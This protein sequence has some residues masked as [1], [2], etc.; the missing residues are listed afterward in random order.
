IAALLHDTV[1]D[2]DMTLEEIG[3]QFGPD[4]QRLV[5]GLSKIAKIEQIGLEREVNSIRKMFIAMSEDIRVILVKLADRLHNI[6]TIDNMP[7]EKQKRIANET[8]NIFAPIADR[9]GIFKIKVEL[10]DIC[11]RILHPLEYRD[12]EKKLNNYHKKQD[13]ILE[14]CSYQLRQKLQENQVPI[15][16]ISYRT[17][18]KYS[19]FRKM[20]KRQEFN[21]EEIYDVFAL[22]IITDNINN[23]YLA[24]GLI[25]K[26]WTP[27]PNRIKD[28]FAVPKHNGYESLHTTIMGLNP[29]YPVEIQI[30]TPE[31]HEAAE[32]GVAA[33]WAYKENPK[34]KNSAWVQ[35]LMLLSK[36]I[37]ESNNNFL[38]NI[39]KDPLRE[40][41][42][43]LTPKGDVKDLPLGAT[44]IDFA[45][46]VHSEVGNHLISAKV[47]NKAVSLDHS[48]Q[49]G[50]I[51]EVRTDK[52][53]HPN[54]AWINV[55]KSN[56][57]R[58]AIRS[59]L[60]T[61]SHEDLL[62]LG[63][64]EINKFLQKLG[65][66]LLDANYSIL[67]NYAK[68]ELELKDRE[69]LLVKIGEGQEKASDVVKNIFYQ[70][71]PSQK[72]IAIIQA[73]PQTNEELAK[74]ILI[75]NEKNMNVRISSCCKPQF[76]EK[77]T[78]FVTRGG[79]V[80][81]HRLN[82]S[83]VTKATEDRFVECRWEGDPVPFEVGFE[84][85]IDNQPGIGLQI[86]EIFAKYKV[87]VTQIN[88]RTNKARN[89]SYM[90]TVCEVEDLDQI[91]W[92][93]DEINKIHSIQKMDYQIKN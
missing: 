60:R 50:D 84:F 85:V 28:Y 32:K 35:S 72:G 64:E 80:S 79:Y 76:K 74:K 24:L 47:N 83:F 19:I 89:L 44:P 27:L 67:K 3:R 43:V 14:R 12:I 90:T 9:L 59:Y 41:V 16:D 18:D 56:Q 68:P 29:H 38:E 7:P 48:L 92:L 39:K 69:N 15:M 46:S 22:R 70:K 93:A 66:P 30:R 10:E 54:P 34:A 6:R 49:N 5:D 45:Y 36:D 63:R 62:R 52:N 73:P 13:H 55:V 17:K 31:A 51:V 88:L 87:N 8:L 53:R 91:T 26:F 25:H 61:Q 33:H 75:M 20:Q 2:T 11:F 4:V 58:S 23:C 57:A 81:I 37:E 42:Y 77:I 21:L 1:E 78:G 86:F 40:Q 82:C 71:K 65:K